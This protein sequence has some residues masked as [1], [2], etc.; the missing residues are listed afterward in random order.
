MDSKAT[1]T[2]IPG[3]RCAGYLKNTFNIVLRIVLGLLVWFAFIKLPATVTSEQGPQSWEAVLSFAVSHHVQ[4]GR[5]L[6]F[7]YGP[8]GFLTSGYYWGNHFWPILWWSFGFSLGLTILSLHFLGRIA[9]SIRIALCVALPWL[10]VAL[11]GDSVIDPIYLFAITAFGTACLPEERSAFWLLIVSGTVLGWLCLIK[12]TFCL[13]GIWALLVITAAQLFRGRPWPA[14]A[15]LGSAVMSFLAG[16]MLAGQ[17]IFNI[18]LWFKHSMQI[19]TGY[20]SAMSFPPTTSILIPGVL[21][22]LCLLG[23]LLLHWQRSTKAWAQT[24]G[25]CLLAAGIFLA[26]KEGFVRADNTHVAVF[27]LYAALIAVTMPAFLGV[28][29]ERRV[30]FL[31][32]TVA[33]VAFALVPLAMPESTF[34]AAIKAGAISKLTDTFTALFR[35]AAFKHRLEANLESRRS[36]VLLPQI[37]AVVGNAPVGVL[38]YDQ[39]VAILNGF[40]YRPHPVFQDYSAYTPELQQ[41]NSVFFSSAKAPGYV[42]WRYGTIGLRFP[43]LDDGRIILSILD[44]YSPVIKEGEYVLWKRNSPQSRGYSLVNRNTIH[45]LLGQWI[46]IPADAAWIRIELHETWFE[47][48]RKFFYQALLPA[49]EVRLEDG[50]TA[51]YYLPPGNARSGFIVNPLLDSEIDLVLPSLNQG[52]PGRVTA[53]RVYARRWCFYNSVR[54]VVEKIEGIPALEY[55]P[56]AGRAPVIPAPLPAIAP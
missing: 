30:L 28:A 48:V 2:A 31:P 21:T 25:I 12:F 27:L 16:W 4:W 10:T 53:V 56:D 8:L 40:N 45:A 17:N 5:D 20:S 42:L 13:Y 52:K 55:E 47:T 51:I 33:T 35:P 15:V 44:S 19:A 37:A 29:R 11:C 46:P 23:L 50:R 34:V 54:Y 9:L 24:P 1:E 22:G 36:K 26:W 43:T 14:G 7:T 38:N 39:D 18:G 6:V 32:L 41:L 3:R 49:I